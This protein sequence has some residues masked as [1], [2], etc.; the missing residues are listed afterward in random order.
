MEDLFQAEKIVR[1][2]LDTVYESLFLR[3]VTSFESFV[4]DL[5]ISILE[6]RTR[7]KPARH[8]SLHM[9]TVSH[10]ALMA[11]LLQGDQ[12]LKWLPFKETERR[13]RLYLIDG[14]PFTELDNG[15]KSVVQT[16]NTIRNAIAHRSKYAMSEF[17][18]KVIGSHSLLPREKNPAGY[19]QSRIGTDGSP[20]RFEVYIQ[21]LGKV[22]MTLC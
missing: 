10:E 7:Y 16:I 8:V 9:K 18:T 20:T 17:Q 2:D 14:K 21:V 3:G 1:R 5:F 13:A 22:A 15:D 19:L 6:R 4:E 12:Y 11:I